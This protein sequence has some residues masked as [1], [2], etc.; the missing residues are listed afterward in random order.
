[1]GGENA[2][3]MLEQNVFGGEVIVEAGSVVEGFG[4]INSSC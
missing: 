4:H 2:H 1:V 3:R